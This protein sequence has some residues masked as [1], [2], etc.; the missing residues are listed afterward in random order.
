ME[1][2]NKI[3]SLSLE[4]FEIIEDYNEEENKEFKSLLS[5]LVYTVPYEQYVINFIN[6]IINENYKN[7]EFLFEVSNYNINDIF[8][9]FKNSDI[10]TLNIKEKRSKSFD[11]KH[12][13]K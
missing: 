7:H 3:N 8:K 2:T 9:E 5:D 10:F 11:N 4:K 13:S 12:Y 1:S 6:K